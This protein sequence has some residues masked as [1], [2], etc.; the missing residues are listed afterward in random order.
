MSPGAP[1]PGSADVEPNDDAATANPVAGAFELSGDLVGTADVFAWTLGDGDASRAWRIEVSSTPGAPASVGLYRPDGT[2]LAGADT[3]TAGAGAVAI[4][5]L[6]LPAGTY[7]LWLKQ[8]G[9]AAPAYVL[10]A[11][12]ETADVFD[13]EPNDVAVFALPLDSAT[14]SAPEGW[15]GMRTSTC[16]PSTWTKPSRLRSSTSRWPGRTASCAFCASAPTSA[17]RSSAAKD[18]P[19]HFLT[20]LRLAP[21]R[22]TLAVSGPADLE[23]PYEVSVV[24]GPAP[25][26]DRESEP[27]DLPETASAWDPTLRHARPSPRR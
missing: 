9:S 22:Y 5:D 12:E 4:S 25:S 8:T 1:I 16:T 10:R 26:P 7:E 2:F 27:N 23:D 24:S 3:S 20:D 18:A 11:V 17:P 19:G 6:R 21:G 15:P 13:P 14:R